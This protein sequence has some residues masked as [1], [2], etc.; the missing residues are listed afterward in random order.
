MQVIA[1]SENELDKVAKKI[2]D[3][4]GSAKVWLLQGQLGAG[5][6]TLVKNI[7]NHLQVVDNMSSP[8]YSIINEYETVQGKLIYHIDCYRLKNIEEAID[9]GMEEY[10]Y[11]GQYCFIEWPEKIVSL[12]PDHYLTIEINIDANECRTFN[13]NKYEQG[14][15]H[16]F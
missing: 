1:K 2:I 16:R 12:M 10:L 15:N 6:T 9:I 14:K 8:T 3:F 7:G 4:A 5:K 11:S 13:V